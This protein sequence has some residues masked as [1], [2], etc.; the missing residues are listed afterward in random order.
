MF[1]SLPSVNPFLFIIGLSCPSCIQASL[2][3]NGLKLEI[4]GFPPNCLPVSCGDI[5]FKKK[6]LGLVL[7]SEIR[8]KNAFPA[9]RA[10]LPMQTFLLIGCD[11]PLQIAMAFWRTLI[12]SRKFELNEKGAQLPL[13]HICRGLS[14]PT[15]WAA[16]PSDNISGCFFQGWRNPL[17]I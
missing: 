1:A 11:S 9:F 14:H 17:M 16:L 5:V 8:P 6:I 10:L 15:G 7:A 12:V 4:P 13:L 2:S 3:R